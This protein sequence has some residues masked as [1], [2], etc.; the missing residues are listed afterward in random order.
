LFLVLALVL[1][2]ML[3]ATVAVRLRSVSD[4][5]DVVEALPSGVE[6]A[7]QDVS[8]THTEAGLVRWRL[9]AERAE[10]LVSEGQLAVKNP[11]LTFYDEQGSLQTTLS[12]EEGEADKDFSIIRARGEVVVESSQGYQLFADELVY[13][14]AERKIYSDSAVRFVIDNL[15]VKGHGLILDIE[16]RKMTVLDGVN[17]ILPVKRVD[18]VPL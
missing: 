17:A 9:K 7:L 2:V 14:Q 12:A 16:N 6:L 8:Y 11:E 5:S 15:V 3:A 10:R 13:R 4:V 18:K 1:A